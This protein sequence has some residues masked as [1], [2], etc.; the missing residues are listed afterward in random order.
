MLT[1]SEYLTLTHLFTDTGPTGPIGFT[2]VIGPS[3]LTV[4]GSSGA[5]GGRGAT[6]P[7]GPGGSDSD[8][9]GSNGG[10][11]TTGATGPTGPSGPDGSS[12]PSGLVSVPI[13]TIF[14]YGGSSAPSGW[15]LCNGDYVDRTT[16][17]N[18][19]S[20]IGLTY[21]SNSSSTFQLPDL[22]KKIPIGSKSETVTINGIA[23]KYNLGQTS[24]EEGHTTLLNELPVHTHTITDSGHTHSL[25]LK[26][27]YTDLSSGSAV[28][29]V[30]GDQGGSGG[31]RST[32]TNEVLSAFTN[33]SI[34][35]AGSNVKHNNTPLYVTVN[36]IIKF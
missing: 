31:D 32:T 2:G 33:I 13:G 14:A 23:L 5:T 29:Y 34:Q 4:N 17:S 12:G 20:V 35:S 24:G 21:G 30:G 26:G 9:T 10:S 3:G 22:R 6:G 28:T 18:L 36:Y 16:Y 11:G 25:S 27:L 8:I 1:C 19:Y 15:L 7:T